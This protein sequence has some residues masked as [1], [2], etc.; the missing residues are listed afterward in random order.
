MYVPN[1]RIGPDEG[2]SVH[3]W[4][5]TPPNKNQTRA[6][7]ETSIGAKPRYHHNKPDQELESKK[8]YSFAETR[9][10]NNLLE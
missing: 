9:P 10:D 5:N 4:Q 2:C 3:L 6:Q 1:R 8:D 7:K